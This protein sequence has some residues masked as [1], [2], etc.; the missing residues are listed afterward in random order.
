MTRPKFIRQHR[1]DPP[2]TLHR[3]VDRHP[4]P[5]TCADCRDAW[6]A[7]AL[8]DE[9]GIGTRWLVHDERAVEVV[10]TSRLAARVP[11]VTLRH[12]HRGW[13]TC[14]RGLVLVVAAH[15]HVRGLPYVTDDAWAKVTLLTLY[16]DRGPGLPTAVL[17]AARLMLGDPP[18]IS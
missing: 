8:P 11:Q 2:D 16:D 17:D 10:R 1:L 6:F 13:V 5:V 9:H 7:K 18:V 15:H 4:W 12:E 14:Q 3:F